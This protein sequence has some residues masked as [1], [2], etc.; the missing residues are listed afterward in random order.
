MPKVINRKCANCALLAIAE[1]REQ[2]CWDE[3]KCKH[4]RNYYR[5]RDRKLESKKHSYAIATGKVLPTNFEIVPD[6]YRAELVLYGNRPNKLGQVKGGVKAFQVLIYRGSSLVSQSNQVSCAGTI[7]A[8]LEEAIDRSLE[9][10]NELYDIR[11][12]GRVIWK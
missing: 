12:F 3:S 1:S 6:T 8:D 11:T 7:S 4:R 9:Q 2:P 10:I 5:S